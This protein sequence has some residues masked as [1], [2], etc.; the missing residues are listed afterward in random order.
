MELSFQRHTFSS[1]GKSFVSG[2]PVQDA[3][4]NAI[5]S[6]AP[7]QIETPLLVLKTFVTK[8]FAK[9]T[10][11]SDVFILAGRLHRSAKVA[12][13]ANSGLW[14]DWSPTLP[15]WRILLFDDAVCSN[16]NMDQ[17]TLVVNYELSSG[18]A[19][20]KPQVSLPLHGRNDEAMANVL[21]KLWEYSG[22]KG[23]AAQYKKALYANNPCRN[24][25]E[26]ATV[27]RWMAFSYTG[28]G[29]AYLTVYFHAV[30]GMQGNL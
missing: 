12:H 24:L 8:L 18:S 6:I 11:T 28:S 14:A 26:T 22:W 10:V 9:P 4:F 29:G 3:A 19:T 25:T 15:R 23:L 5:E 1:K 30:G 2:I 7:K 13:Q 17:L 20:P 21:T 16:S 27:Q